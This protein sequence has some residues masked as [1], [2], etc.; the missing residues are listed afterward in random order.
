[1]L[2]V[3]WQMGCDLFLAIAMFCSMIFIALAAMVPCFSRSSESR[4]ALCRS[5]GISAEVR[6]ISSSSESCSTFIVR[7]LNGCGGQ[8]NCCLIAAISNSRRVRARGL[9]DVAGRV[10]SRGD[11]CLGYLPNQALEAPSKPP[12]ECRPNTVVGHD[13]LAG[14]RDA[15]RQIRGKLRAQ[16]AR[17][18]VGELR[19]EIHTRHRRVVGGDA[20]DRVSAFALDRKST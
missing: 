3:S 7:R 20:I 14:A 13:L 1:M 2:P 12:G 4:M 15:H 6:R 10:P 5:S 8:V 11:L 18:R 19:T 16:P 9:Q 17:P